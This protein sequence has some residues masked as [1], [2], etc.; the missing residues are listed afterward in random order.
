MATMIQ[1]P[2]CKLWHPKP[3][4]KA[5]VPCQCGNELWNGSGLHEADLVD[6]LTGFVSAET[7]AKETIRKVIETARHE[8]WQV[9]STAPQ[10]PIKPPCVIEISCGDGIT[11][12]FSA[13]SIA[14][15]L[16][17]YAGWQTMRD[18][19]KP[20]VSLQENETESS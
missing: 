5:F 18:R 1:C 17:L 7:D 11:Y 19:R 8:G 12:R 9:Y 14:D 2:Q 3:P 6:H 15:V 10:P 4:G 16:S 13:P 20:K